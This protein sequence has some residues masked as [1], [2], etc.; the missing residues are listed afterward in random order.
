M[1]GEGLDVV[2]DHLLGSVEV[3]GLCDADAV[4]V[5]FPAVLPGLGVDGLGGHWS[6]PSGRQASFLTVSRTT[7]RGILIVWRG[8]CWFLR[9][10]RRC[11]LRG[12]GAVGWLSW[13]W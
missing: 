8:S 12:R 4:D 7:M 1:I 5:Q 3:P 2:T 13:F 11:S 6:H 10:S 9:R